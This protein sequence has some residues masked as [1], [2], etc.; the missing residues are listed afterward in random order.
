M[1]KPTYRVYAYVKNGYKFNDYLYF[2]E[3]K[4]L[5]PEIITEKKQYYHDNLA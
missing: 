5:V 1:G 3:A 2:Q 4:N